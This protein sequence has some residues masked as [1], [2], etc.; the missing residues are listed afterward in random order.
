MTVTDAEGTGW[1]MDV[2][3]LLQ[4]WVISAPK[5]ELP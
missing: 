5:I 3:I 4:P 2:C 1:Y